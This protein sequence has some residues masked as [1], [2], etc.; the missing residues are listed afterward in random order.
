MRQVFYGTS[1][2]GLNRVFADYLA[3]RQG[4]H[5]THLPF[6]LKVGSGLASASIAV[7]LGT[8]FDVALV[9]MQSDASKPVSER[10]NYSSVFDALGRMSA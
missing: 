7:C 8:P 9:R 4:C 1:R 3:E 2:L 6:H 5:S 10:R